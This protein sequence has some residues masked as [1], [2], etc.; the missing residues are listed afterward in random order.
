[1]GVI[2]TIL[3]AFG[4][5]FGIA[6]GLVI[7]YFLF[8]FIQTSDVE[9]PEIRPLVEQDEPTLQRMFPEIPIWVKN[10]DHDRVDWLNKF[11]ELMWPYLDKAI[12]KTVLA[13]TEPM[14]KEQTPQYKIDE[15][16]FDSL[17][18]G[19]LPPTFQGMKVY[20]TDEKEI[21]MEPSFKWA[22]NPNILVGIKAFGLRPTVQ[23]VDLQVFAS[24]R[25][26]LKPLVPTFPC[27]CKILVSLM[28][29]PHVDFGVKLGGADLMSIPGLY[30]FVQETIKDQVASMYLWPKVLEVPV[31]DPA[32]AMKRP[33]G[34]LNVKVIKAM[35]LKKKDLLGASDPYAKLRLTDDKLP[36]KKTTVKHKNLNPEWNEEFNLVVKD[37]EVQALE[38]EVFDW[39]SVGKH[40]KMGINLVPLKDLTPEEPKTLTIDLLKNMD[41]NDTHNEK[42]RGQIV[43]ALV[44]KPFG[45]ENMPTDI[46]E[47]SATQKAPAG[48]PAGGGLLVVIIHEGEDLEGKHHTNPSVRMLFHGEEKRTK[49]MKKNRDPR[50]EEEFT[51]TLEEPPTNEKI[52]LEVVST[53]KRMG[54]IHPKES[55]GYIDINL[56]DVVENKRINEKY[57]L[58]DSK[59][60]KL[61]VEMQWR[62]SG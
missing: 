15:V 62:A 40:D 16:E 18:L 4:F 25:I 49:P 56:A 5:G 14:I 50:W 60:G 23:V 43:V 46:E 36:S 26:T 53:S 1:M 9:T 8:I 55:L 2:S 12:C 61:Q 35:K 48:T 10:P 54:L 32:K 29:K 45:E 41:P 17:T 28:E 59:N 57:H 11:I 44:Y 38:I 58:I 21:I 42:S 33:V 13:T 52:H 3:G 27:F 24:P 19:S 6:L 20:T 37:P 39:E 51:F 22:A 7:G 47:V 30:G 34:M 31:L